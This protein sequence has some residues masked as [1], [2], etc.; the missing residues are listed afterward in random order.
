MPEPS[1]YLA[2]VNLQEAMQAI[3]VGAGYFYDVRG[4]A[5]KLDPNHDVAALAGVD[6]PRPFVVL[7]VQPETWDYMPAMRVKVTMPVTVHWISESD[8]ARDENVLQT[9][10]RGCADVERAITRDLTRGGRATDTRIVKRTNNRDAD[11]SEVWAM[12]DLVIASIRT[13]GEPTA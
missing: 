4:T 12:V 3:N 8:P 5:V 10:F 1:D 11:G 13:F 9:F 6:G 2:I 7:E